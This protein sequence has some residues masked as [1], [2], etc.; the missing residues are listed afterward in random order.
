MSCRLSPLQ[1][2]GHSFLQP[3]ITVFKLNLVSIEALNSKHK[4]YSKVRGYVQWNL[5]I[6]VTV[7]AGHLSITATFCGPA[8]RVA[9]IDRFDCIRIFHLITLSIHYNK[10]TGFS[11]FLQGIGFT[12]TYSGIPKMWNSLKSNC[13]VPVFK[14]W[15][16]SILVPRKVFAFMAPLYKNHK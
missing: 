8:Q 4:L 3:D 13:F 9:I 6:V 10:R 1:S 12:T 5:S 15:D 16:T 14:S 11:P 2:F 7:L